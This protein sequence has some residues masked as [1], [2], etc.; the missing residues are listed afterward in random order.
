MSKTMK[1]LAKINAMIPTPKAGM[2]IDDFVDKHGV[3]KLKALERTLAVE[4]AKVES[5]ADVQNQITIETRK[6]CIIRFGLTGD[7]HTG[8]L[9]Q[10]ADALHAFYKHCKSEGIRLVLD[11]GDILAGH[12]VYKGQEFELRDLGCDAQLE[13]LEKDAPRDIPTKFITGNHD[14]SFKNEAGIVVGKAIERAVPEYTF[15]GEE[16]AQIC[17]QTPNGPF[18]VQLMHPGGGAKSYALSYQL[19]NI[20]RDL[21]G[22]TKPDMLAAGHYHKAFFMPS[23]RNVA[24]LCVGT[25]EKQTPFMARNGLAAHVGG[26]I[27]E[28][29]KGEGHNRIKAEFVAFY[30]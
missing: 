25:F 4:R 29:V 23:F 16:S 10:H 5:L 20:I 8:S 13:R 19:Q 24:G 3:A 26:W 22:G 6:D 11:A 28:V 27:V 9:Y 18:V 1:T 12:R 7:R 21:S 15:L 14:A 17:F 30:V 2:T